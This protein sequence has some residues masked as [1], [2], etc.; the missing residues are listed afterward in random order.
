M[1]DD[2]EIP[3]MELHIVTLGSRDWRSGR[4]YR[5]PYQRKYYAANLSP[6]CSSNVS[7]SNPSHNVTQ[8]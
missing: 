2:E 1:I 5:K 7:V 6:L 4:S 3:P 8:S